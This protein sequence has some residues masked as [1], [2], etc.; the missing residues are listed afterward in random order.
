MTKNWV[1]FLTQR[2]GI[3]LTEKILGKGFLIKSQGLAVFGEVD[4]FGKQTKRVNKKYRKQDPEAIIENLK[5]LQKGALVVHRDYGI[6]K[7]DGLKRLSVDDIE[8]EFFMY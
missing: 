8:S 2:N 4:L 6:G 5:N 7:Y 3:Y 1:D